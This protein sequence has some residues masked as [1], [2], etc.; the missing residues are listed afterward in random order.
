[1]KGVVSPMGSPPTES[2]AGFSICSG[3]M[4]KG[5]PG[6]AKFTKRGRHGTIGDLQRNAARRNRLDREGSESH[7]KTELLDI[8]R[9]ECDYGD[10][11]AN[12]RDEKDGGEITN[13]TE[14]RGNEASRSEQEMDEGNTRTKG[15]P[16]EMLGKKFASRNHFRTNS[17]KATKNTF[18]PAIVRPSEGSGVGV[19][20]LI[21]G[22]M[23]LSRMGNREQ[24]MS[25]MNLI[26]HEVKKLKNRG[27][28]KPRGFPDEEFAE[29][30]RWRGRNDG[31]TS[32]K[33]K[34]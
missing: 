28:E 33:T 32:K 23:V 34:S 4:A 14:G 2:E 26:L 1:M 30:I 25:N 29:R 3:A 21:L 16:T 17:S 20:D 18:N 11:E 19:V 27:K 13:N 7:I 6:F 5:R 10:N 12:S 8:I 24:S 9:T 22:R 31:T 15:A